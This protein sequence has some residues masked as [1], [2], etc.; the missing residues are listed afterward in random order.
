ML[1]PFL[2]IGQ[3]ARLL[4]TGESSSVDLVQGMLDRIARFDD[5]VHAF[6]T[7]C[8]DAALAQARTADA[9][10]RAGTDRGPLHGIP[11]ALKDNVFTQGVRTTC[12]S[13]VMRDHV[14]DVDAFVTRRLQQ[15]GAVVLGKASLWEFA[16]GVPAPN[17]EIPPARNPWSLDHSPGG[18]SS[19]SGAAV[20]AGF[21]LGAVGTD[22]GGSIRHPSSVCGVVGMKPTFGLVSQQGVVPVSLSLD[23]IGPMTRTVAD[24]ALMLQVMAGFDADDP[25]SREAPVGLDFGALIGRPLEGLRAGVPINLIDPSGLDA[26]VMQAFEVALDALR[27]LGLEIEVF[28]MDGIDAV[29]ADST[30]I[31]EYEAYRDHRSRLEAYG[32]LYGEGLRRRLMNGP[33]RSD[34]DYARAKARSAELRGQVDHLLTTRFSVLLMPGREAPALTMAQLYGETPAARGRMTRLG[35]L[36]GAPALVLPMG[37]A[38]QPR[39]PLALQVVAARFH[40]PVIYQVAAAYEASQPWAGQHPAWLL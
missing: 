37:F 10:L 38:E 21:A 22:T 13:Q 16:Y 2:S 29:H 7:V 9:E 33:K 23:H 5:R 6:I 28:D 8:R 35:N 15:A 4:R 36:T 26:R 11:V 27:D 18:S 40:E 30:V 3:A 32:P 14:P 12:H 31:L 1:D 19:G 20:A 17:D 24:N 25:N 39:L 34:Q